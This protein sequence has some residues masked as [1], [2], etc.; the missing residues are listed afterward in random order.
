LYYAQYSLPLHLEIYILMRYFNTAVPF[1]KAKHYMIDSASRLQG[2]EQ[3]I[4]M[5]PYFV[6]HTEWQSGKTTYLID[7]AFWRRENSAI[8]IERYQYN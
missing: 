7:L 2:V 5:E 3:L 6:I 4:D 8:W 1:N